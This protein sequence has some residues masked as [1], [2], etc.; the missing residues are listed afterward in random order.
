MK[1]HREECSGK[2]K[3]QC[4]KC[5]RYHDKDM[6][7]EHFEA[8]EY[9]Y[10][11]HCLTAILASERNKHQ[12][13][14]EDWHCAICYE[15]M[16]K[17]QMDEHLL[18]CTMWRCSCCIKRFPRSVK[19][20]H[21]DTCEYWLC[22]RCLTITLKTER[23]AHMQECKQWC[24]GRCRTTMLRSDR[25][26]HLQTCESWRCFRCGNYYSSSTKAKHKIECAKALP[27]RCTYCSKHGLHDDISKHEADCDV[28]VCPGCTHRLRVDT[29]Q[30]HWEICTRVQCPGCLLII[31][32]NESHEC[33]KQYCSICR[34]AFPRGGGDSHLTR[35]NGF[36]KIDAHCSNEKSDRA[37]RSIL[38]QEFRF[39][40]LEGCAK[41]LA[42][43]LKHPRNT[44]IIDFECIRSGNGVLPLQ[45]AIFDASE[46]Q[47][48]PATVIDHGITKLQLRNK[49]SLSKFRQARGKF[50]PLAMIQK[51]Y[52]GRDQDRT[53]GTSCH[54][55]AD[56]IKKHVDVSTIKNPTYR[57]PLPPTFQPANQFS[58]AQEHGPLKACITWGAHPVD[59][60]C[61]NYILETAGAEDLFVPEWKYKD[62]PLGWYTTVRRQK[63]LDARTLSLQLSKLYGALF[64]EDR[65][66]TLEA[67]DAGAD[68]RM[69]IRLVKAYLLRALGMPL[70]GKIDSFFSSGDRSIKGCELDSEK[71]L[72]LLEEA[73]SGIASSQ[74]VDDDENSQSDIDELLDE[75]DEDDE[76]NEEDEDDEDDNDDE[77]P[78]EIP[79]DESI[80]ELPIKLEEE[81]LFEDQLCQNADFRSTLSAQNQNFLREDD[82]DLFVADAHA[83]GTLECST[84]NDNPGVEELATPATRV[85]KRKRAAKSS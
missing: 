49:I 45:V 53:T 19:D 6:F 39:P 55:I 20:E 38:S 29:I 25:D 1:Q 33:L 47:V 62:Q 32:R 51:F 48:V 21:V 10:C 8:C 82:V 15:R 57:P 84:S 23:D 73:T 78:G 81:N 27:A 14:C 67:H 75:D 59:V 85:A 61:L 79:G 4:W 7:D 63:K 42:I 71:F 26:Q 12:K 34:K 3:I 5:R 56:L 54:A 72:E 68:V 31:D 43:F 22:K 11:R 52:H 80:E 2:L 35:C 16:E 9:W 13:A 28:R 83:P 77:V 69:T 46:Q 64:P 58:F 74:G 70:P 76:E 66:L 36:K 60:R 18:N 30:A 50:S 17:S 24:C 41:T 40:L 44:L 37:I 65:K